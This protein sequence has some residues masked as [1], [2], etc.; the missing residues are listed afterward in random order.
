MTSFP[1]TNYA[2]GVTD[3]AHLIQAV[4]MYIFLG[5]AILGFV[6]G[7]NEVSDIDEV[8]CTHF[9]LVAVTLNNA[10]APSTASKYKI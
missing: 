8:Q 4:I 5:V 2:C 7:E 9:G 6:D 1:A 10:F 3:V